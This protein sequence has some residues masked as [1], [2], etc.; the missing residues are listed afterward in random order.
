MYFNFKYKDLLK[1]IYNLELNFD[2]DFYPSSIKY[3]HDY[4]L[5]YY[6]NRGHLIA[7]N[8]TWHEKS[9]TRYIDNQIKTLKHL[10]GLKTVSF[11]FN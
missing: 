3:T 8:E 2:D 5:I 1:I 7:F 4:W 11:D 9:I 10:F 6:T